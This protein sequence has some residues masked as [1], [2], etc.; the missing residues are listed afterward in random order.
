MGGE[1]EEEERPLLLSTPLTDIMSP[2]ESQEQQLTLPSAQRE[3]AGSLELLLIIN[4][5]L[6]FTFL[7]PSKIGVGWDSDDIGAVKSAK[8]CSVAANAGI[9]KGDR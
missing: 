7:S 5:V 1:A 9:C 3:A 8:P 6:T 2:L 4:P